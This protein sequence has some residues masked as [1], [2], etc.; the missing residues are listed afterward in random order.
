[1]GD[2]RIFRTIVNIKTNRLKV[3]NKLH[4]NKNILHFLLSGLK[5]ILLSIKTESYTKTV[6]GQASQHQ[7]GQR[8]PTT[9]T[10]KRRKSLRDVLVGQTKGRSDQG[11]NSREGEESLSI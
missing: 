11:P 9:R 3:V 5:Q 2:C 10:Y 8:Q 1:M 7:P 4:K 6:I